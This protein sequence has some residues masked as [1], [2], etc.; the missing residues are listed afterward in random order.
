MFQGCCAMV[1]GGLVI[2][3]LAVAA[4]APAD[5]S[6]PR[7]KDVWHRIDGSG[8]EIVG[9]ADAAVMREVAIRFGRL[10]AVVPG[11][12]GIDDP[13]AGRPVRVFVLSRPK[14]FRPYSAGRARD[15]SGMFVRGDGARYLVLD[16]SP[17]LDPHA[18]LAHEYVHYIL[19][20][21]A[22][23]LPLWFDEGLAE[24]F[25]TFRADPVRAEIGLPNPRQQQLLAS[26]GPIADAK[27]FAIEAGS[28]EYLGG[29]L[30]ELYHAQ[31]WATVHAAIVGSGAGL[32]ALA[33]FLG[34][35]RDGQDPGA[36]FEAEFGAPVATFAR[37]S[38]AYAV[39]EPWVTVT[40]E[41]DRRVV[42][43]DPEVRAMS[44]AETLARL[45]DLLAN[46]GSVS[47]PSARKHFERALRLDPDQPLALAGV[48]T[49]RSREQAYEQ[50]AAA[51]DRAHHLAP[52]DP[53]IAYRAARNLMRWVESDLRAGRERNAAVDGR[54]E[55]A[56]DRFRVAT[57]QDPTFV[58]AYVG[59]GSSYLFGDPG[60][61]E[62]AAAL[63][64]ARGLAPLDP[65]VRFSRA[66]LALRAGRLDDARA[67]L[68][69]LMAAPADPARVRFVRHSLERAD[70]EAVRGIEFDGGEDASGARATL[71]RLRD[72]AISG[73]VRREA[74]EL[75]IDRAGEP[76]VKDPEPL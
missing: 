53:I 33:R 66:V 27:F 62:A 29:A 21:S 3:V 36:V 15:V 67:D 58:A 37:R 34:R 10:R 43:E 59:L 11:I 42:D 22:P 44:H 17:P 54:V 20:E 38:A 40:V 16:A 75:L 73:E 64:R 32:P 57:E 49:L 69:A 35:V 71:R 4:V 25:S 5:A 52:S 72:T 70:L 51:F 55:A 46:N 68:E 9:D 48:G 1:R 39:Q 41:L 19:D 60:T 56:R 28:P 12:F 6:M 18:I 13:D 47:N 45:G 76:F 14:T 23:P 61:P 24:L 50:A 26:A 31:A 65:D 30:K 8:F 2:A 74:S 63:D 7:P